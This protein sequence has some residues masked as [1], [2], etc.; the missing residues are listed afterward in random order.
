[1][2]RVIILIILI[3]AMQNVAGIGIGVSPSDIL[4]ENSLKGA[5]Y[6]KSISIYNMG[7]ED[8]NYSLS[9]SGDI[10]GWASFY[11]GETKINETMVPAK[12]DVTVIVRFEIPSDAISKNYTGSLIIKSIP[13][14]TNVSGNQQ[15]LIIGG[16]ISVMIMVTGDQIINGIVKSITTEDVEQG[17]PLRIQTF[18]SNTGNVVEIPEINVTIF[19][20]E[21]KIDTFKNDNAKIRP[22]NT[23]FIIAEW[24]TTYS[25]IPGNYTANVIVNLNGTELKSENLPFKILPPG[26]LTRRGKLSNLSI[27]GEPSINKLMKV[28]AI[29]ANTGDIDTIAK[30]KGEIYKDNELVNII[31]SDELTVPKL[32]SLVLTSYLR[33]SATG[34]YLIKGKVIFD[35]KETNVTEYSFKVSDGTKPSPGFEGI[36]VLAILIALIV[37]S[38]NKKT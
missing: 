36:Y 26:T 30:F 17:Y 14:T 3:A 22:A 23:D 9:V 4:L 13:K 21:S 19:K 16:S 2:K 38:K 33:L 12:S 31:E 15:S 27:E 20:N 7:E 29:F 37:F 35:G 34:N 5:S 1:M 10:E 8:D 24:N 28:N 11:S 25:N 6:E 18:F 32:N